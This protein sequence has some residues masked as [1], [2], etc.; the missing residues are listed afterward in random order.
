MKIFLKKF[1][2][3]IDQKRFLLLKQ[4]CTMDISDL[5][6]EEIVETCYNKKLQ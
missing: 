2:L 6:D 3:K 5:N 1:I 4:Y